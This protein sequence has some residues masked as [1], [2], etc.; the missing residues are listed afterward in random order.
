MNN[1]I[2]N[3]QNVKKVETIL[4]YVNITF[5]EASNYNSLQL[6]GTIL[7]KPFLDVVNISNNTNYK[8]YKA[9]Y[10]WKHNYL[11]DVI[12]ISGRGNKYTF[13]KENNQMEF[14]LDKEVVLDIIKE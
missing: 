8:N 2:L 13:C 10:S 7:K 3:N 5:L 9:L 14:Y 11:G 6:P 1:I 12:L 4:N